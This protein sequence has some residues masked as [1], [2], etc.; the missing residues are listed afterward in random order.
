MSA[1]R[2]KSR[3]ACQAIPS[4]TRRSARSPARS[5]AKATQVHAPERRLG[6]GRVFRQR[7]PET[8]LKSL[9]IEPDFASDEPLRY[10]H[11]HTDGAEIYFVANPA[12]RSV[13]TTGRIPGDGKLPELW[14]PDTGK[15]ERAALFQEGNGRTTVSLTLGPSGSVF[16]VFR[17]PL[18]R[19][20]AAAKLLHDGE[21]VLS[22]ILGSQPR[23]AIE[24]ATY[25]VPGNPD[26]TRDVREKVQQKVDAGERS[27]QVASLV[28]GG[29]PA[30]NTLKTLVVDY[31]IGGNH[32]TVKARTRRPFI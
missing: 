11:R 10:I 27:F 1:P 15:L 21:P 14:W 24:R 7:A 5:G 2:P 16:V 8:V 31:V 9:G 25:G 20:V 17:Q 6:A 3:P 12:P 18:A 4:A 32:Y 23:C 22:A 30:P 13:S 29:D 19:A 26:R 28:E